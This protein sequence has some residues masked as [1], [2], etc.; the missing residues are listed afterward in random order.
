MK[1]TFTT[2]RVVIFSAQNNLLHVRINLCALK[3]Y[4]F[5]C[6]ETIKAESPSNDSQ[7]GHSYQNTPQFS[8]KQAALRHSPNDNV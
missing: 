6:Y 8:F 4:E 7:V 1:S 3:P 5:R 2:T